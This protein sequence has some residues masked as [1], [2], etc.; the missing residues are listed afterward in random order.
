MERGEIFKLLRLSFIFRYKY[1]VNLFIENK[2]MLCFLYVWVGR[3]GKV[4]VLD[5]FF[6]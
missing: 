6:V 5:I 3:L 2:R 1:K 4:F